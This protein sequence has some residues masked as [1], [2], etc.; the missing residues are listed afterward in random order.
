MNDKV[1][2]KI[3][4]IVFD[5]IKDISQVQSLLHHYVMSDLCKGN[6]PD[7]SN[8]AYFP[9]DNDLKNHIYLA[10]RGLQFSCLDQEYSLNSAFYEEGE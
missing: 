4:E 9:L 7:P 10:K 5:G 3:T 1:G 8:R 6:P 2:T